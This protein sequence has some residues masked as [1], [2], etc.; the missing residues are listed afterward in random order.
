MRIQREQA[1]G[2]VID[3]QEKLFPFIS[4]HENLV[5]NSAILIKGL[6]VLKIPI[7]ITEHPTPPGIVFSWKCAG[8][9]CIQL[10]RRPCHPGSDYFLT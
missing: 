6:Q 2:L 10:L 3:I 4:G 5:V 7:V 9:A 8:E 1:A